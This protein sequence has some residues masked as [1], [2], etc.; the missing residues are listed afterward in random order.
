LYDGTMV[1]AY[2]E[3]DMQRFMVIGIK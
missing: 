1:F 2:P 3:H